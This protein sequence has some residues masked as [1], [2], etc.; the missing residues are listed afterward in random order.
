MK[1]ALCQIDARVGDVP[2]NLAKIRAALSRAADE[3][4]DLAVFPEQ[5]LGGYPALDLWEEPGFVRANAEALQA[6]ARE[7]RG[8]ACLVGFVDKNRGRRGKPIANAA[9]LL[10]DGKVAAVR[11]KSLLPAYDVFDETRYF[12]PASANKPVRFLGKRLGITI[13]EDAWAG[14]PDLA[15]LYHRDPVRELCEAGADLLINLSSSPFCRGKIRRRLELF[16]KGVRRWRRPFFYCNMV[17]GN[18]EIILDGNSLAFDA[19]GR[20]VAKGAGF[21]ED[22]VLLDTDALPAPLSDASFGD[23]TADA[24]EALALGIRDYAAKVGFKSALVGLSGGIDSALVAA[25]AARALG[26]ERVTGVSMPSEYSSESSLEDAQAL[27]AN[28]GIRWLKL[29]IHDAFDAYRR[30]LG[31]LLGPR[32]GLPEQNLQSRIRGNLLMALSNREGSL[33]LSTGNKSEMSVGYCTLYGDMSGGLA[34]LADVPKRTVYEL[35]RWFNR[36]GEVIPQ[37]SIDKPPSAE[38]KPYQKD[39]DDLPPYDVLDAILIAYIER[40]RTP[41]EIAAQ[42]FDRALV[43]DI[44][45]RID[46]AEYKRRQAPPCLRISGKAFGVGRR[47]PIARGPYR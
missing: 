36:A 27:A 46:R 7:R 43:E 1:L 22:L 5:S 29:P 17:G 10:A 38:L 13:C 20:C 24:A 2:G 16:S 42:G 6:L 47:M 37:S 31:D 23:D 45:R 41:E 44:V 39:Q 8:L 21:A 28:L 18:D 3:G 30:T 15:R 25:L 32:E 11:H 14:D 26:P 40:R 19:R 34:V 9:A 33:L 12:E 35:S 4:A